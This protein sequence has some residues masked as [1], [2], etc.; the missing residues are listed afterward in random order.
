[1]ANAPKPNPDNEREKWTAQL[2]FEREK[3]RG[4]L[5]LKEREQ[6]QREAEFRQ[7]PDEAW[8]SR[9]TNPLVLAIFGATL[10]GLANVGAIWLTS[11]YQ[12]ELEQTKSTATLDLEE[13]KSK[14]S[15]GVEQAKSEATRILEMIKTNDP[16]KAAEN[17][18]FLVDSGLI[19]DGSLNVKIRKFLADRKPGTGPFLSVPVARPVTTYSCSGVPARIN[20]PQ[21]YVV[22]IAQE[23]DQCSF[24]VN[25]ATDGDVVGAQC[26][27]VHALVH[28]PPGAVAA[29]A[30]ESGGLCTIDVSGSG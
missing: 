18:K 27:G 24:Y 3:W 21:G 8:L 4:E 17:L 26:H 23:K 7:K 11:H 10:T 29:A 25:G 20:V 14:A 6:A 28:L 2:E 12:L 22:T 16:D 30:F 5:A 19:A 15:L 13:W 9:W 1:M